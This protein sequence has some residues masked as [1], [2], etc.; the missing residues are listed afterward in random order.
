MNYAD[1]Q[2]LPERPLVSVI[3]P[4]Y[5]QGD[6]IRETIESCLS[7]DYRPIEIVVVD[8]ASTD[9]TLEVLHSYDDCEELE[10][11]SEPDNGPVDAVN[12]GLGLVSGE[13][14]LIQSADDLSAEGAFS[15]AVEVFGKN[16]S[17]GLVFG[18]VKTIDADGEILGHDHTGPGTAAALLSRRTYAPQPAT[19]FRVGLARELGGWDERFPYCPDTDLWFKIALSSDVRKVDAVL[20]Y[21]RKHSCQRDKETARVFNS[22]NR[23]IRESEYLQSAP[24]HL[25]WAAS[26]GRELLKLRY[27]PGLSDLAVCRA[28]WKAVLLHPPLI[29]GHVPLHRLVPGYFRLAG[30]AGKIKRVFMR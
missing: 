10:W 9:G 8:G 23:M 4:S 17:C 15:R 24:V 29:L 22:Y 3:V 20:G 19:F 1:L 27:N 21:T 14:G 25:R 30:V 7:Q 6:Y 11:I 18:E 13:I 2:P 26:A 16:A 12:K 5:N 28:L